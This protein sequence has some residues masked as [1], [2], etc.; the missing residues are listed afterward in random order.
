LSEQH[1]EAK[2]GDRL[3]LEAQQA[4]KQLADAQRERDVSIRCD[5]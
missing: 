2:R 4:A 3:V 5:F 1:E